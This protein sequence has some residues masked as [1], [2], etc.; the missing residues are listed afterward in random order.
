[1]KSGVNGSKLRQS[2]S[3]VSVLHTLNFLAA[4]KMRVNSKRNKK[5]ATFFHQKP[6]H[7]FLHLATDALKK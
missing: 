3:G 5:L 7:T 6:T 2:N 4:K 1:M